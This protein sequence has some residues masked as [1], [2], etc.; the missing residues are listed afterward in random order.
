MPAPTLPP[1]RVRRWRG[2]PPVPDGCPL[3]PAE[4]RQLGAVSRGEQITATETRKAQVQTAR[5]RL[6]ARSTAEAIAIVTRAGWLERRRRARAPRPPPP[7]ADDFPITPAMR[8]YLGAFDA[9]L[10]AHR[11]EDDG[12]T[13]AARALMSTALEQMRGDAR[14]RRQ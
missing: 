7:E 1:S 14:R 5:R 8:A 9:L 2:L 4:L 12:A 13:R 3:S 11:L 10:Y 6:G